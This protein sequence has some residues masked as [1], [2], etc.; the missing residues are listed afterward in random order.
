[1]GEVCKFTPA[2]KA[3][4]LLTIY[5]LL[6][7]SSSPG[8]LSMNIVVF[9]FDLYFTAGSRSYFLRMNTIYFHPIGS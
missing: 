5:Q 6:T 3:G 7:P 9:L 4:L 2:P 8:S 1:M